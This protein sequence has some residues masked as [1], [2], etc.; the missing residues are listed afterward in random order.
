MVRFRQTR[1]TAYVAVLVLVAMYIAPIANAAQRRPAAPS[2]TV[3]VFPFQTPAECPL[4]TLGSDIAATVTTSLDGPGGYKVFTMSDR[5]PSIKRALREGAVKKDDVQGPFGLEKE[6]IQTA[7]KIAR[8]AAADYALVGS[9]DDVKSDEKAKTGDMTVSACLIDV[10]TGQSVRTEVVTGK[11]PAGSKA[12][13]VSDLVAQAGGD[14]AAKLVADMAMPATT[15][16]H[17]TGL[18]MTPGM[19]TVAHKS[20]KSNNTAKWIIGALIAVGVGWAVSSHN[21]NNTASG[22]DQ[23]QPPPGPPGF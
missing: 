12:V 6:N 5:M 7:L 8:E 9:V 19:G 17:S 21:N 15:Y 10:K 1:L 4:E 14:A 20:S 16:Q 18:G 2:K 22:G 13:T 23:F 3:I 11:V